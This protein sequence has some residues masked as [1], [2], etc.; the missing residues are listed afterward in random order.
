MKTLL[1]AVLL[2]MCLFMTACS[3][4]GGSG[5]STPITT[6]AVV[7]SISITNVN[8]V[9]DTTATSNFTFAVILSSST[10]DTVK[11]NYATVDSSAFAGKD[12]TAVSGTL[13]F[14]PGTT[15]GVVNVPV[16]S[17]NLRAANQVFYVLLSKPV[18]ATI[19][20]NGEG[21]GTIQNLGNNLGTDTSGYSTPASYA[22]YNLLWSDEFTEASVNTNYWNY[23]IGNSG[24]GNNELECYTSSSNNS[25]ISNGCLVISALQQPIV[26]NGISSN[27]TSARLNTSGK[28]SFQ[29]GRMDI[30][31]KLPVAPGMWPALWML[32]SNF[33]TAGWPACGETDLMELVGSNPKQVTGS[34]HWQMAGSSGEGT[35]NNTYNLTGTDFSQKFHVFTLIWQLNQIQMYVD[36][37]LYMTANSSNITSG[38][39][40]FNQPQ[41]LIFNVAVGGNWPGPPTGATIFP[42]NMYIDYVRVFQPK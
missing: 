14:A 1:S 11:V 27:Y 28:F 15:L 8:Q 19:T 16:L 29:Y 39:W 4:S 17:N 37:I 38:S 10:T 42:Q 2:S 25:F 23:D 40:P 32:G 31:A 22:G 9:R 7:P 12:Y 35:I 26:Y 33:S 41:F 24:W 30:R 18:N 6:P 21:V 20:G 34:I 5:G 3:K 36:D 13:V